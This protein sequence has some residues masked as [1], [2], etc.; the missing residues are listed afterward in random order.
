MRSELN[1]GTQ[2]RTGKCRKNEKFCERG[3]KGAHPGG[4]PPLYCGIMIPN[5]HCMCVILCKNNHIHIVCSISIRY[6]CHIKF[7]TLQLT[8]NIRVMY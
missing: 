8:G 4:Y 5:Y 7:M 3:G 6:D 2:V 1:C